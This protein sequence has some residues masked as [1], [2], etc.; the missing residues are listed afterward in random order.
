MPSS[1]ALSTLTRPPAHDGPSASYLSA[2]AAR[3][4]LAL[5]VWVFAMLGDTVSWRDDGVVFRVK[6]DG[7]VRALREG[8]REAWVERAWARV[9]ARWEGG[10]KGYVKLSPDDVEARA[11]GHAEVA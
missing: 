4:V 1:P 7:S 8:E 3:E 2:W 10:R 11:A 5:P 6:R 9:V